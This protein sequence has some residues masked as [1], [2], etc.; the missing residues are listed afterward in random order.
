MSPIQFADLKK[1]IKKDV[2]GLLQVKLALL[3]DSST[4]L[5]NQAIKGYGISRRLNFDIFEGDYDQIDMLI[6]DWTPNPRYMHS[7]LNL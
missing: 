3:G 5:L 4:Q 6:M 1:N 2:S 7:I